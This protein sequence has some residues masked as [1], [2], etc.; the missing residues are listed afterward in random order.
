MQIL[1]IF[2]ILPKYFPETE[3]L[4]PSQSRLLNMSLSV[5]IILSGCIFNGF[6][7][8]TG[9]QRKNLSLLFLILIRTFIEFFNLQVNNIC[10]SWWWTMNRN[11]HVFSIYR[12]NYPTRSFINPIFNPVQNFS[13]RF[14][15]IIFK[16]NHCFSGRIKINRSKLSLCP[17]FLWI[18]LTKLLL[19]FNI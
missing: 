10:T 5:L 4:M 2:S 6:K 19:L 13:K 15:K 18:C 17:H 16:T 3:N 7:R 1:F 9:Q 14:V 12:L 11:I 8:L